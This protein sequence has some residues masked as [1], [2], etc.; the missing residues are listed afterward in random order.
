MK[1]TMSIMQIPF[2]KIM[3]SSKKIELRIYDEKRQKVKVCDVIEFVNASTGEK[4]K[5]LVKGLLVFEDFKSLVSF[6]P[7]SLFGYDSK[8]EIKLRME[9]LASEE[10]QSEYGVVGFVIEPICRM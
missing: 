7:A 2:S 3:D 8:E 10:E 1:F 4:V 5:C 9:R 6:L